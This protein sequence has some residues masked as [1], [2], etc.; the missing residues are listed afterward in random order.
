MKKA[1]KNIKII[2]LSGLITVFIIGCNESSIKTKKE[3]I[4]NDYFY[5]AKIL[6]GS[7]IK[8]DKHKTI[9]VPVYSHI[10]TAENKYEQMG[11]TLSIRN[12]DFQS[13][14]LIEKVD[15]YNTQ[16]KLVENYISQ[17]HILKPMAST[18]FLVNLTDMRG[19]VGANFIIKWSS[20]K[21][22]SEPIFQAIMVNRSGNK[23]FSF[24]TNGHTIE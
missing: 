2:I 18:E 5:P 24:V 7:L 17:T 13:N 4:I 14:L 8:T 6:D 1:L 3:V 12:T 20:N 15:Y 23:S 21:K 19:G 11:I 9:Y 16:G 10:Y 22:L